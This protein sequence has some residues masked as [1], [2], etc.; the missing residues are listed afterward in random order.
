M[1]DDPIAFGGAAHDARLVSDDEDPVLMGC[2]SFVVDAADLF[3][4][5]GHV[6]SLLDPVGSGFFQFTPPMFRPDQGDLKRE[7]DAG[8]YG[9]ETVGRWIWVPRG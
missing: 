8:G 9:A 3:I 7:V 4:A 6:E 1:I 2:T 5:I